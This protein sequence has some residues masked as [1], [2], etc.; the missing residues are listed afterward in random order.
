MDGAEPIRF[1]DSYPCLDDRTTT[2]PYDPHYFHQAVWATEQI[3]RAVP[4]E[5]V[6]VGSE[7]TF[8]GMISA[9]VP[10]AFVDIRPLMVQLPRLRSVEGDLLALP[11][12]NRSVASLSCLHVAEHVGLGRYGDE[13]TPEGT[14]RAC[15]ELARVLA[16][17]GTLL[18]SV[19]IGL[20]RLCFNAHRV[21]S[22][23][24][25]V[26]YFGELELHEFAV[27]DDE[28]ELVR[29]ADIEGYDELEYGMRAISLS[30]NIAAAPETATAIASLALGIDSRWLR[31]QA[32]QSLLV[33]R[34]HDVRAE[35]ALGESAR[36]ALKP[37]E[38]LGVAREA[39]KMPH[40]LDGAAG[41]HQEPGLTVTDER[42][43]AT[44]A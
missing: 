29:N 15:A 44:D 27:V 28:Y 24:Q 7:I 8:V 3:L 41:L 30:A 6:D 36:R 16:P 13:L 35:V 17:G 31:E 33:G 40:D 5:H 39:L 32:L 11:F 14:R 2:T 43:K 10:V 20:P 18:F 22:P 23:A 12:D 19:P 34:H 25:I 37:F 9:I 21:H 42:G 26:G 38:F 1:R 4:E